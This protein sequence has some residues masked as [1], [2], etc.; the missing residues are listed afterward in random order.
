M[1]EST[2]LSTK[3]CYTNWS[4]VA[5]SVPCS[6]TSILKTNPYRLVFFRLYPPVLAR[7]PGITS[8]APSL[9]TQYFHPGARL[10]V[11]RSLWWSR[12]RARGHFLYWRGFGGSRLWLTTPGRKRPRTTQTQKNRPEAVAGAGLGAVMW[13]ARAPAS[14]HSSRWARGGASPAPAQCWAHPPTVRWPRGPT[15]SAE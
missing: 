13:A 3:P 15:A 1:P 12:E 11:L 7:I 10:S 6:T 8:R 14:G 4:G 9:R 2:P 5:D